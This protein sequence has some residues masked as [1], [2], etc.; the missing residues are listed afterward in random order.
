MSALGG[1]ILRRLDRRELV[2]FAIMAAVLGAVVIGIAPLIFRADSALFLSA[3]LAGLSIG[4]MTGRIPLPAAAAGFLDAALGIDF[5]FL[6][7][8]RLDIPI[9]SGIGSAARFLLHLLPQ[10]ADAA[11]TTGPLMEDAYRILQGSVSV[12]TRFQVWAVSFVR[13]GDFF[14]PVASAFFWSLLLFLAGSFAGWALAAARK[15]L[16]ALL[17]A[18][19]LLGVVFSYVNGDWHYAVLM[20]GLVFLAVVVVEQSQKEQDWERRDMGYSTSIRWDLLFSAV[21]VLGL[22]LAVSYIVPSISIDDIQRWI[23]EQSE[24]QS[25]VGNSVG[26]SFG[27]QPVN[28]GGADPA[29]AEV[30]PRSHHLGRGPDLSSE[31]ALVIVTGEA[32]VYLPG[33]R[34][35]VAPHHYWKA[36]TYDIYSGSGWL[37]SPTDE[38]ELQSGERLLDILPKGVLL[39]QTVTVSR[40][41]FG[42]AY[43][44]GELAAVYRLFRVVSRTNFDVMGVVVPGADYELDSVYYQAD[45]ASLR[46][47]GTDYPDWIRRRYLQLPNVLP[48][49]VHAL[50]RDLTATPPTPYDRA[51]AIE[52]Y[53]RR[54]MRYSLEIDS[55]PYNQDV[56]DYFLFVSKIGFCDYYASAMT[57]LARSA[58][59][60]ARI[61]IGYAAGTFDPVQGKYTV[62]ESDAHAWPELF[63]PGIGWVEFEPTAVMAE[64]PRRASAQTIAA[65]PELPEPEASE[66][67][68]VWKWLAP[69]LRRS[70][71]PALIVL[72]AIPL[73]GLVWNLLAPLRFRMMPPARLMRAVYRGLQAHGTRQ[74]IRLSPGTT[75]FE[76]TDR[77]A[78]KNPDCA[79][80]LGLMEEVYSRQ[81][82]SGR[83]ISRAD[84]KQVIRNWPGVDRRLWWNWWKKKL[85]ALRTVRLRPAR[86]GSAQK[87][88]SAEDTE[89]RGAN[90]IQS[91]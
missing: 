71:L 28:S 89:D 72:L 8:G 66:S 84:R 67:A 23:R 88:I 27:L 44:A 82:Y 16:A 91:P 73:I 49:R 36:Q 19:L 64:I 9:R 58:G 34:E 2:Q 22:L 30:F 77:L 24:P 11:F 78:R 21:P 62:L 4:W 75:P 25:A 61:A 3:V 48:E 69:L 54:E 38:R 80:S 41:G 46:A 17:P 37:T 1:R 76:F 13:G 87:T 40:P 5:L 74:G 32:L 33:V 12:I 65:N 14:D 6:V 31:V 47:A 51:V 50:A 55:P 59:I 70:A 85:R 7:I 43:Y 52:D 90:P 63:F 56:V 53:L 68:M 39:R 83:E 26:Q 35:P 57:V 60:P 15:P 29:Q 42:P 20:I 86:R 81:L 45:E 18:L 79:P 10:N